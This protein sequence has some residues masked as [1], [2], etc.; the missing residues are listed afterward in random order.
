MTHFSITELIERKR[1]GGALGAAELH[2]IVEQYTADAL[3]DYQIAALLMA[4][5]IR[6]FDADELA[7]WT[8][9]MLRSGDILDL[10]HIAAPKVDKH[11]TGGVGDKISIPLAPMVAA[12]GV[13]VPMMSGRGLGHTGGTLDKLE[14]IPGFRTRLDRGEFIATVEAHGLV[15]G[16]QSETMAPA[17]R[18]IYALRDSTGT[19]PSLPLIASSI[20]SKKLAE[21]I[22]GLVLDVKMGSGAFM[23]E[24]TAARRLAATMVEIGAAHDTEVVALLTNMDQPLGHEVGNAGE[25]AE[26]LDVL[27]GG[28][29]PDV[30]ELTYELGTAMLLLAGVETEPRSAR[31]R[32][33]AAVA[34]GAAMEKFAE[35]I[36][37]QGGDPRVVDDRSLLPRAPEQHQI[38]ATSGGF[39]AKCDARAI[40]VAAVRLGAGRER[41]ED[42]VDRAVG[43]TLISKVGDRVGPGDP[44]AT[45]SYRDRNRLDGAL[46]LLETAWE[47]AAEPPVAPDLIVARIG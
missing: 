42:E 7:A 10:G 36:A 45:V 14:S 15:L 5:F 38:L 29:P 22:D 19:V 11:S 17:D 35:V 43:I 12:C 23:Q 46:P 25:I 8:D 31:S 30:A 20:M 40:G 32:L 6:G 24:E 13:A 16:G 41:K 47:L 28:G 9:A 27:A 4:V 26:S 21:G 1:D 39:V 34:S 2:W 33:E 3:P 44:L 37:A 18:R